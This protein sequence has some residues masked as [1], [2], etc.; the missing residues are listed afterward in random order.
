M[1]RMSLLH[2]AVRGRDSRN[3]PRVLSLI[4]KSWLVYILIVSKQCSETLHPVGTPSWWFQDKSSSC[5]SSSR[6]SSSAFFCL[7]FFIRI[8]SSCISLSRISSYAQFF[9]SHFFVSA[10]IRLRSYSYR[11][12]PSTQIFVCISS[13]ANLC[14][15]I[16]VRKSS[17]AFLCLQIFVHKPSSAFLRLHF[18]V[19]KSSSTN[20]RP[21][22]FTFL[23]PQIFVRISSSP[24]ILQTKKW[25]RRFADEDLRTNLRMKMC[26]D[27]CFAIRI[28]A[29]TNFCGAEEMRYKELR[30]W[31][32][33]HTKKCGDEDLLT[34][35]CWWRN[36]Q[37]R[38]ARQRFVWICFL[39]Q[40]E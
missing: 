27:E 14:P 17:S 33:A 10:K 3:H 26:V 7:H 6:I 2:L 4:C 28:T 15:Q 16:F 11:K 22:I 19:R 38:N 1:G 5:I 35:K 23:H 37:R 25:E 13:S 31:R 21:Q 18:F 20:V 9:V 8:S 39:M 36:A 29:E 34:K 40:I 24:N 30:I 32:I 12:Y